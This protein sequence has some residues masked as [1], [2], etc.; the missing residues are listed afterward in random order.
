MRRIFGDE[1]YRRDIFAM[2]ERSVAKESRGY[3]LCAEN[4]LGYLTEGKAS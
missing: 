3:A 4:L 2:I 1:T